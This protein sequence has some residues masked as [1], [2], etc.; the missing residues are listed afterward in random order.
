[1]AKRSKIKTPDWILKGEKGTASKKKTGKS[2]KIRHCPKCNSDE[3]MVVIGDIGV[4]ECSK[5]KWKGENVKL[6]ELEE[7]DFMKYLDDKGEDV[8]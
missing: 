5:C 6:E 8:A 7:E 3:V 4:W 2:F 1:M